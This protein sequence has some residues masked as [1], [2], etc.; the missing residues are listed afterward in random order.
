M[1]EQLQTQQSDPI[2]TIISVIFVNVTQALD[3]QEEKIL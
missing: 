2:A 1:F 3:A